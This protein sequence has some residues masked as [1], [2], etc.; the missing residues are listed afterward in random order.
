MC[1]VQKLKSLNKA[2]L[3][4]SCFWA[5]SERLLLINQWCLH[6]LISILHA[7]IQLAQT[8]ILT[9]PLSCCGY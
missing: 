9:Q 6:L 8:R 7:A 3:V 4:L 5:Y 2:L 1:H